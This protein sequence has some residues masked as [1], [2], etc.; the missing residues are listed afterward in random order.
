MQQADARSDICENASQPKPDLAGDGGL[1]VC[2]Q[3]ITGSDAQGNNREDH[4]YNAY[5]SR[6]L[7]HRFKV[8]GLKRARSIVSLQ[9]QY[10]FLTE[11][12]SP[13]FKQRLAALGSPF[14]QKVLRCQ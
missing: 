8:L 5:K 1:P 9:T 11:A 6:G 10:L 13:D 4:K 2:L 12:G 7:N 3:I 14:V